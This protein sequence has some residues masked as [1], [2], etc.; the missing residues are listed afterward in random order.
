[1]R[2]ITAPD[3]KLGSETT[4]P[5][6]AAS[7]LSGPVTAGRPRMKTLLRARHPPLSAT[8]TTPRENNDA[9]AD[10]PRSHHKLSPHPSISTPRPDPQR[11]VGSGDLL[12]FSVRR[13]STGSA[14]RPRA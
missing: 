1:L 9:A 10:P 11:D 14:A 7:P 13:V 5:R 3:P 6:I 12:D 4:R 8:G 2:S